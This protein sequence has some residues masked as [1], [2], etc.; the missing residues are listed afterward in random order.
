MKLW[1]ALAARL[2]AGTLSIPAHERLIA[3]LR[4]LRQEQ[5]AFGGRWR[6]LDSSRKFHR[7]VSLTLAGA[8]FAVEAL[9]SIP[10]LDASPEPLGGLPV[11]EIGSNFLEEELFQ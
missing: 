11:R 7:D 9:A 5:F 2:H 8:C 3:Q 4:G 10:D 6:V 1:G